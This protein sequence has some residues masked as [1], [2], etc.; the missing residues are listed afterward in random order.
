MRIDKQSPFCGV[1]F[2]KSFNE[3]RSSINGENMLWNKL[4][5]MTK[6]YGIKK[7]N[8]VQE[9]LVCVNISSKTG[10]FLVPF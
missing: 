1:F 4:P 7:V 10:R 9:Y 3:I 8:A 2:S 5:A 6:L